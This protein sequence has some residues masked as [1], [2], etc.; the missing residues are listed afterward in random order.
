MPESCTACYEP[1]GNHA[2]GLAGIKFVQT[3]LYSDSGVESRATGNQRY[4]DRVY[5]VDR[6]LDDIQNMRKSLQEALYGENSVDIY[7]HKL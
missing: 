4:L 3:S 7:H 2:T 6:Y 1:L 5:L